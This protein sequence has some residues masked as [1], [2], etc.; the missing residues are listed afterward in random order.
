MQLHIL[1]DELWFPPVSE[2]LPDGL[3]AL[4]GDL[5][6]ERL[7]LAYRSGIFPWFNE[8]DPILWWSPHPRCVLFPDK[9]KVSKSMQQVVKKG[10]FEFRVNSAFSEVIAACSEVPREGQDGTWIT[11]DIREAYIRLHQTGYVWSAEAWQDGQLVGG[12]YGILM[13]KAFFG[14]SMFSRVSNASKFAFISWVRLLQE[15]GVQLIDCQLHTPHL[16]SLGA[17][18][19]PREEFIRLLPQLTEAQAATVDG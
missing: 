7:I 9:L 4:G 13:G 18:M 11:E 16:E 8:D 10:V 2:A 19:I 6:P 15:Q 12:L 17:E 3:L 14:E 1:S 5:R